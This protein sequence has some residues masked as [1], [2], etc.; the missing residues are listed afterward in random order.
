VRRW[1]ADG[2]LKPRGYRKVGG[3]A[4]ELVFTYKELEEF[5]D[6]YLITPEDVGTPPR[7]KEA[8]AREVAEILGKLRIFA[9]KATA[10]KYEKLLRGKR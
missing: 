4:L 10:A 5:M 6:R 8:R 2:L 7:G 1:I 3:S 9:G